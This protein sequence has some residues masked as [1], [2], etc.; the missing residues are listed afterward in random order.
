MLVR[1]YKNFK[2]QTNETKI[3]SSS[4]LYTEFNLYLKDKCSITHPVF[5][6]DHIDT[7]FNYAYIPAWKRY[8]FIGNINLSNNEIM[9]LTLDVDPMASYRSDIFNYSIYVERAASDH[10]GTLID[11]LYPTTTEVTVDQANISDIFNNNTS[12][13]APRYLITVN[14]TDAMQNSSGMIKY[15]MTAID[16]LV[17]QHDLYDDSLF[18]I[19]TSTVN[20]IQ[21]VQSCMYFPFNINT[22]GSTADHVVLGSWTAANAGGYK[23][24][25]KYIKFQTIHHTIPEHPQAG[26]RPWL[27][28][29]PY[30]D[31]TLHY[32][33]FGIIHID[34]DMVNSSDDRKLDLD[35]YVDLMTGDGVLVVSING[36]RYTTVKSKVGVDVPLAQIN[37]T[38]FGDI[39]ST[40]TGGVSSIGAMASGNVE[41]GVLVGINTVANAIESSIPKLTRIGSFGSAAQYEI[42]PRVICK[43]THVA[44]DDNTHSGRPLCK[45]RTLGNM[46]GFVKC[47]NAD[48]PIAGL[49]EEKTAINSYLNSGAYIN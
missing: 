38:S 20:P 13:G 23:I 30:T 36:N 21:Y 6:I 19:F 24:G 40:F 31:I 3:P 46:S 5:L 17:L 41:G 7:E 25:D 49:D 43:F 14:S 39:V 22:A 11:N 12:L 15:A 45:V 35:I 2:K 42:S 26:S 4:A 32:E 28:H 10:D 34:P 8:Y 16:M 33:P 9:E 47:L 48:V 44:S 29:S 37:K 1:F 18:N 27:N